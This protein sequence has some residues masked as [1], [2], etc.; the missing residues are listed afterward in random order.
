MTPPPSAR[1]L[2]SPRRASAV[3]VAGLFDQHASMVL[4]LCRLLLRD[5]HEAEDAAQ[6]TFVSAYRS[7]L[8]GSEPREDGPWLAA[9]ARNECR[10]RLRT[11]PRAPVSLDGELTDR[12]ADPADVVDVADRRAELAEITRALAGLPL[13]QRE[14]VALRDFLGLSYEEVAS[15]LAVSVPVVESLLFRA[16]RRLRDT[17]RTVPRYAAGAAAIPLALRAAVARDLPDLDSVRA[18][19]G[20]VAG[21]GAA[22]GAAV[23][24]IVSLPF[25]AKTA[26][27]TAVA[28][29]AAGTAVAPQ[30]GDP[31]LEQ[32]APPVAAE[33]AGPAADPAGEAPVQTPASVPEA[34]ADTAR[35]GSSPTPAP[36]AHEGPA[37]T[38]VTGGGTG[39]ATDADPTGEP[40]LDPDR[41]SASAGGDELA[42]PPPPVP[43]PSEEPGCAEPEAADATCEGSEEQPTGDGSETGATPAPAGNDES[44]AYEVPPS[45]ALDPSLVPPPAEEPPAGQPP[46]EQPP[47]GQPPAGQPP[48]GQPPAEEPPAEEPP[49]EEAPAEEPSAGEPAS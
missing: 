28:I 33:L 15:T 46:A 20:L 24:K 23:A 40:G 17:V 35:S 32:A 48:A 12:L 31:G 37:D 41:I 49:A 44:R 43:G 22:L 25:A 8:R 7:L 18:G 2:L 1:T 30:V 45:V 38:A 47:A 14:A 5:H 4:G 13:R 39:P 42:P 26:T 16:R 36:P 19:A 21:A 10:A 9:I 34:R 29:V 27:A 6:Q 3:R 11:R